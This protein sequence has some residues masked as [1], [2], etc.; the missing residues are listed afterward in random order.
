MQKQGS[1]LHDSGSA[2]PCVRLAIA[3]VPS[4]Q[5][6]NDRPHGSDPNKQCKE[7]MEAKNHALT[8]LYARLA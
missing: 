3:F 5:H 6:E 1:A 4:Q 7:A 8:I 2:P